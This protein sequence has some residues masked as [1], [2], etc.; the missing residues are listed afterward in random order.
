MGENAA[1]AR[2]RRRALMWVMSWF[3]FTENRKPGSGGDPAE[4]NFSEG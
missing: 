4:S 3:A 1:P 2:G